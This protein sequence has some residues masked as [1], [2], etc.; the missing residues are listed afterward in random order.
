MTF[1][2]PALAELL[3]IKLSD[4]DEEGTGVVDGDAQSSS[5]PT[6]R[7]L[8]SNVSPSKAQAT[9]GGAKGVDAAAGP[10]GQLKKVKLS[11]TMPLMISDCLSH[12]ASSRRRSSR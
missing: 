10:S 12:L 2:T 7:R 4:G 6:R 3:G 8:S 9:S 1:I 5:G 11:M